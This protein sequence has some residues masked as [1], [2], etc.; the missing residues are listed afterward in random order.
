MLNWIF[1]TKWNSIKGGIKNEKP[2]KNSF[3]KNRWKLFFQ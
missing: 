3:G 2:K 1:D